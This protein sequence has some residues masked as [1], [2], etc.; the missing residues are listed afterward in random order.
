[1]EGN[2]EGMC[3]VIWGVLIVQL[4][5]PPGVTHPPGCQLHAYSGQLGR[6]H[7]VT[8]G[9]IR[10][11]LMGLDLILKGRLHPTETVRASKTATRV[12][13]A[14]TSWL[15]IGATERDGAL[16]KTIEDKRIGADELNGTERAA[17]GSWAHLRE[18]CAWEY[19]TPKTSAQLQ[20]RS[21]L[22]GRWVCT[23]TG[24]T[25]VRC[26]DSRAGVCGIIPL[27]LVKLY[28]M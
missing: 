7:V 1:M 25:R 27:T 9:Y 21:A 26:R 15:R 28:A 20:S 16:S 2:P 23:E 5:V 13:V 8:T 14:K 22:Q 12:A 10:S 17:R 19:D 6:N 24:G 18:A 11:H 4:K 3:R